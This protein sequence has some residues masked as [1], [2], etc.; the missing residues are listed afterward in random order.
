MLWLLSLTQWQMLWD[1][2]GVATGERANLELRTSELGFAI[3][4]V[5]P[6]GICR[7]QVCTLWVSLLFLHDRIPTFNVYCFFSP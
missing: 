6:S 5:G 4:V 1:E 7:K 3:N 2:T